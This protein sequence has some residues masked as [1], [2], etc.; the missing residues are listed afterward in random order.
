MLSNDCLFILMFSII[1]Y[2]DLFLDKVSILLM[3]SKV[4][5][6]RPS[7]SRTQR[8]ELLKRWPTFCWWQCIYLT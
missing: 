1:S 4:T 5:L 2:A 6:C 3:C 7:R 8:P